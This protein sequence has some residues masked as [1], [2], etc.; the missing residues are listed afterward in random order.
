MIQVR[1][2]DA[3]DINANDMKTVEYPMSLDKIT[4]NIRNIEEL[5]V[6]SNASSTHDKIAHE[7]DM[8][9]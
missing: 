5:D 4:Q 9:F 3:Q 1:E 8:L 2:H 6:T 7:I